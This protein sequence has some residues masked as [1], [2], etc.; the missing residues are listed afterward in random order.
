MTLSRT[1][2]KLGVVGLAVVWVVM[3]V[4]V[5]TPSAAVSGQ[6]PSTPLLITPQDPATALFSWTTC[7]ACPGTP[8][9]TVTGDTIRMGV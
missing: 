2:L 7:G 3:L 6:E 5:G 4:A 1:S 8:E 9:V